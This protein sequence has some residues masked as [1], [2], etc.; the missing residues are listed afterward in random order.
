MSMLKNFKQSDVSLT[1]VMATTATVIAV[2]L[3]ITVYN[4]QDR[5]EKL[6][7]RL[8]KNEDH[9]GYLIDDSQK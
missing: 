1:T 5:I 9:V 8:D 4:Q 7:K 6:E 3:A 2:S